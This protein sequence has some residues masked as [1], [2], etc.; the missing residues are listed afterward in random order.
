MSE[1]QPDPEKAEARPMRTRSRTEKEKAYVA[2][3]RWTDCHLLEKRIS[4]TMSRI[5]SIMGSV[6]NVDSLERELAEFRIL[7]EEFRKGF[8][9]LLEE[10]NDDKDVDVANE[11]YSR[12]S[13]RTGDFVYKVECWISSAKAKIE[14][15]LES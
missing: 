15:N 1:G 12:Q 6:D 8:A 11:W 3:L 13:D 9:T 5:N 10:L 2:D 7:L 14:E 4:R